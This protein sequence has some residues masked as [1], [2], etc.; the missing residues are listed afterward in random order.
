M[1]KGVLFLPAV[2]CSLLLALAPQ[3]YAESLTPLGSGIEPRIEIVAKVVA[4]NYLYSFYNADVIMKQF[5]SVSP[6]ASSKLLARKAVFDYQKSHFD[7]KYNSLSSSVGVSHRRYSDGMY[8]VTVNADYKYRSNGYVT[9]E[10][11]DIYMK[12]ATNQNALSLRYISSN[13]TFDEMTFKDNNFY[14]KSPQTYKESADK[15]V[16]DLDEVISNQNEN[17]VDKILMSSGAMRSKGYMNPNRS[18]MKSYQERWAFGFNPQWGNFTSMGGDCT[19]YASQV[20]YAGVSSFDQSGSQKWYYY[21][22]NNRTPSWTGVI[23]LRTYLFSNRNE[24]GH[25]AGFDTSVAHLQT[26]DLIQLG[27]YHTLVVYRNQGGSIYVSAHTSPALNKPLDSYSY[28]SSTPIAIRWF[29][30]NTTS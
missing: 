14:V 18:L 19:N 9:R 13:D 5:D 23:P 26:G 10:K 25:L 6:E 22:Y 24:V 1:K 30:N 3:A 29:S 7:T 16:R 12:I 8:Y 17:T 15:Y 21:N 27:D 20:L 11:S 28:S 2:A 4:D